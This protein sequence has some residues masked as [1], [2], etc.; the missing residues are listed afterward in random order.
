MR[1][2]FRMMRFVTG[3]F[4][5]AAFVAVSCRCGGREVRQ[6]KLNWECPVWRPAQLESQTIAR[7]LSAYGA[8]FERTTLPWWFT[9]RRA[10]AS[11]KSKKYDV[12]RIG[13]RGI[14][15]GINFYSV[16]QEQAIGRE[17][18][19]E[20]EVEAKMITDPM[21][22]SYI[23]RLGQR[24]VS[25]SDATIPFVIKVLDSDTINAFALARRLLLHQ[26]RPHSGGGQRS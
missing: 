20:I 22:T 13:D 8:L 25:H 5:T 24:L 9:F 15:K 16:T 10:K 6:V 23:E 18:S 12:N 4:A 19:Q 11:K 2:N 3:C 17:L 7:P 21:V 26:L 1:C 14:G